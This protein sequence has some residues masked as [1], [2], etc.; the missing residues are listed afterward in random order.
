MEYQGSPLAAQLPHPLWGA[1]QRLAPDPP[2]PFRSAGASRHFYGQFTFVRIGRGSH[3][4][5]PAK[6][7]G[8]PYP[9]SDPL[10]WLVSFL[11]LLQLPAFL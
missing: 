6:A 5:L 9:P 1:H 10:L 8:F 3:W 4:S 7:K 11:P 2:E